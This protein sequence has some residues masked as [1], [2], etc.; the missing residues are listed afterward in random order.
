MYR[1]YRRGRAAHV[2]VTLERYLRRIKYTC[3]NRDE[4]EQFVGPILALLRKR[5]HVYG[6]YKCW[7]YEYGCSGNNMHCWIGGK[8]YY[9]LDKI[10]IA[11]IRRLQAIEAKAAM[12]E[13]RI[14]KI[15]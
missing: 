15:A 3:I 1:L 6:S 4:H 5:H 9:Y 7:I 13:Q 12:L 14:R 11:R 8:L 10:E 2:D